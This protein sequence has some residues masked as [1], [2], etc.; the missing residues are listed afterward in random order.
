MGDGN[1]KQ[2]LLSNTALK[3]LKMDDH[4]IFYYKK[5]DTSHK[6][7]DDTKKEVPECST[8]RGQRNSIYEALWSCEED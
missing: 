4:G 2:R 8:T 1:F 6:I 3:Q 7:S 5:N